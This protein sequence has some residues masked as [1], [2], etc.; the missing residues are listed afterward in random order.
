LGEDAHHDISPLSFRRNA[1]RQVAEALASMQAVDRT[2]LPSLEGQN[3]RVAASLAALVLPPAFL[4]SLVP[5]AGCRMEPADDLV[6]L[7]L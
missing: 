1:I 5:V 2:G 3:R 4:A 7:A 6:L